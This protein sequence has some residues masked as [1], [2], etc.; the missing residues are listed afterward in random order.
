MENNL[1][2]ICSKLSPQPN[3][4]YGL[5]LRPVRT[6]DKFYYDDSTT[7][8][9][10]WIA[11]QNI[12]SNNIPISSRTIDMMIEYCLSAKFYTIHSRYGHPINIY[13]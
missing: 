11:T 8:F 6:D 3:V 13:Q 9:Y 2:S 5:I 7:A 10:E 12:N 4:A 1:S